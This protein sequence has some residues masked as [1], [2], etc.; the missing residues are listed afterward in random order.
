MTVGV[1][2]FSVVDAKNSPT[3]EIKGISPLILGIYI[4]LA[5]LV[6]DAVN[7]N[8]YEMFLNDYKLSGHEIVNII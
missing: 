7:P 6:I 4:I 5:A 1:F 2:W 3:F 8:I